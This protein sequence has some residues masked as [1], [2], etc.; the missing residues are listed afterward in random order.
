[1]MDEAVVFGACES[2]V[3]VDFGGKIV[4]AKIDTG[5]T[6]GAMHVD[7]IEDLGDIL[8]IEICGVVREFS[9]D[10]VTVVNVTSSNGITTQRYKIPIRV[11]I[12]GKTYDVKIGITNRD[13]MKFPILIGRRFLAENGILV[14]VRKNFDKVKM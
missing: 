1:M 7:N 14:D 6:S 11:E 10:E 4:E 5:A 9:K 12:L 8:R 3:L 13:N 2:V